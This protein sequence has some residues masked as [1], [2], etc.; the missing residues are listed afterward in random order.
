MATTFTVRSDV[1][2]P[3]L[4]LLGELDLAGVE[5][6]MSAVEQAAARGGDL[7]LDLRELTFLDS[8][9]ISAFVR[10]ARERADGRTLVLE[11]PRPEVR[12]LLDLVGLSAAPNLEIRAP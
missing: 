8:S 6:L 2:E 11:A 5:V 10:I 3:R 12:R 9:G 1:S 4:R 7:V